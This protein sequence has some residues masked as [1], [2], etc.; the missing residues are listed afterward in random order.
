MKYFF[1]S[2][3]KVIEA[4]DIPAVPTYLKCET[5]FDEYKN[6]WKATEKKLVFI[7]KP[8]EGKPAATKENGKVNEKVNILLRKFF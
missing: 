4:D 6:Q 3:N 5:S 7:E 2:I 1:L 8:K